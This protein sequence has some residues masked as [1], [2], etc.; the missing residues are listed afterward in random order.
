M[1]IIAIIFCAFLSLSAMTST[2]IFDVDSK[3]TLDAF[4]L[5]L[6]N[7]N[8]VLSRPGIRLSS[9]GIKGKQGSGNFTAYKFTDLKSSHWKLKVVFRIPTGIRYSNSGIYLLY[10]DP[11]HVIDSPAYGAALQMAK[12]KRKRLGPG[13][14]E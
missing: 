5:Y 9:E 12:E 1:K 11:R 13:P 7:P 8:E 14:F 10:A 2:I 6:E 3:H 4:Q